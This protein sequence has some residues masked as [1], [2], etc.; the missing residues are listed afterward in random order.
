MMAKEARYI[1]DVTNGPLPHYIKPHPV[2]LKAT[3]NKE[4]LPTRWHKFSW[5]V[6]MKMRWRL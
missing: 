3:T 2:N 4:A 5:L 6:S 1:D